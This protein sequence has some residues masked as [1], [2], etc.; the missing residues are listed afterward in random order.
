[1]CDQLSSVGVE[2]SYTRMKAV[3]KTVLRYSA[4]HPFP[5]VPSHLTDFFRSNKLLPWARPEVYHAPSSN[6]VRDTHD[7]EWKDVHADG[8]PEKLWATARPW[9]LGQLRTPTSAIQKFAGTTVRRPG[10]SVRVDPDTNE[11]LDDPLL[12]TGERV[13]SSVR[14]RLACRGLGVDDAV[15]WGCEGLLKDGLWKLERGTG[16][17]EEEEQALEAYRPAELARREDYPVDKLYDAGS[18]RDRWRWV[19]QKQVSGEEEHRMPQT[20]VLPEEPMVGYWE[21]L[22]LGMTVGNPDVWKFAREQ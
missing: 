6:P 20:T 12:R 16:Y 10:M 13:H 8:L 1:M 18:G 11:D 3:F 4:A 17:S 22:L 7:C 21:R 5:A 14:V 19:Y 15:V 9:A 2:F